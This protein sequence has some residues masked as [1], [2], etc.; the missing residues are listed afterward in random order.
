MTDKLKLTPD[1]IIEQ[2]IAGEYTLE[3]MALLVAK[4][5]DEMAHLNAEDRAPDRP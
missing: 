4:I 5:R 1:E 3:E 2:L